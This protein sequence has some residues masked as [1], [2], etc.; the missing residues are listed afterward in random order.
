VDCRQYI[1]PEMLKEPLPTVVMP[2]R[3]TSQ[4]EMYEQYLSDLGDKELND[5]DHKALIAAIRRCQ[6]SVKRN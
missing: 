2:E 1:T 6:T 3:T 5:K 4:R